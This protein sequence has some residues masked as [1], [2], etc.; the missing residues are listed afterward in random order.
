MSDWSIKIP[1]S[2]RESEGTK[3]NITKSSVVQ[4]CLDSETAFVQINDNIGAA[5]MRKAVEY[6]EESDAGRNLADKNFKRHQYPR[7]AVSFIK[8]M[9]SQELDEFIH[10]YPESFALLVTIAI[11]MRCFTQFV[12]FTKA[13]IRLYMGWNKKKLNRIL[14][15]LIENNI[16]IIR[17]T[18]YER[19][20]GVIYQIN[21]HVLD[22]SGNQKSRVISDFDMFAEEN[23]LSKYEYNSIGDRF[24]TSEEEIDIGV[25]TKIK[26][27]RI[28]SPEG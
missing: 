15:P 23:E 18:Q 26:V 5:L 21:P 1:D 3:S 12:Q 6:L 19:T 2:L 9:R 13:S 4:A 11:G 10:D 22:L 14:N 24:E 8:V 16:L 17:S 20:D 28:L 7:E 25:R 27:V